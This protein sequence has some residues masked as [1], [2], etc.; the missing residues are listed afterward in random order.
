[1]GHRV[2]I[3]NPAS[4]VNQVSRLRIV[5]RGEEEA[6]VTIEGIDDDGVSP[7]TAVELEVPAGASHTVTAEELES[8]EGAG[9]G[10][11]LDDGQGKWQLVVTADQPIEV[12]S[13]L[14]SPT[15]HLTNLSTEP[16]AGEGDAA[17]EHDVPL[18]AAADN[19]D[20]YQGFVRIINRSGMPGE[21]LVEA[22]DDDGIAYTP[23][24]LDI[25]AHETV[26]FNSGDLEQGNAGKGLMEGVGSGGIGDWRLVL[27]SDLDIEVLAYNRTDDGLLTTL[28]DLVPYTEGGAPRRGGGAGAPC[29]Y[30]QPGEQRKSGKPPA[31]H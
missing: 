7:G 24:A 9:L 16:E 17:G 28:H 11:M 26:H 29:G 15:G 5:N 22:F 10:G 25:D 20:R 21:V 2:A 19:A 27:R 3:F 23:V 1:M 4:N 18:F 8:G 12:M 31:G 30:L 6:T 13:L 14:S